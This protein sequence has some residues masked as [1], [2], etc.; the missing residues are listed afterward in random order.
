MELGSNFELN[1][2]N[3]CY[4]EENIFWYLNSYHT[5]FTDSG[6]SAAA[7]LNMVIKP[8]I[9]LL[10]SYICESVIKVYQEKFSLSFY[11]IGKDFMANKDEFEEK[12]CENV[13][14]VYVMHYFG[15]LQD[16]EL[17]AYLQKK[18]EQYGFTIIEDTT[19]SIFTKRRTIGDYCICSL[20][21]WFPVMDGGVLYSE[22][23]LGD[24]PIES[25]PV[26][27][28][29]ENLAAMILKNLYI[30][31]KIDCNELY[32]KIFIE[33]EEKLDRQ[34][35]AFQISEISRALLKYFSVLELAGKRKKNYKELESVLQESGIE[36]VLKQGE[37]VPLSCPIYIERRDTFRRY[38]A[39]HQV[40]C[41]VHW[42]LAGTG[43]EGN[44]QAKEISEH[45]ISLPIDQRY[46]SEHMQYL[47][48]LIKDYIRNR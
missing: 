47:A 23:N 24:I 26:K 17:L 3:L 31:G 14:A 27:K 4:T 6:R 42:P 33:E 21:K 41:A 7:V 2:S 10:P 29:S 15:Q 35:D 34:R 39:K 1:M 20:R 48:K 30:Q 18:K 12:L 25:I 36:V 8:G 32:R 5:I 13:V 37:F 19:H 38:L 46:S 11:N 28:P 9:L 16:Q 44:R 40:Y 43:L 22:K 45:I